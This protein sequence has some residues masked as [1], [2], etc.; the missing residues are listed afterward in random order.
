MRDSLP[1]VLSSSENWFSWDLEH[2]SLNETLISG[3]ATYEAFKRYLG[4]SDLYVVPRT[5]T[6]LES[7]L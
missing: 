6:G 3:C 1:N 4:G 2:P 5:R 7:K